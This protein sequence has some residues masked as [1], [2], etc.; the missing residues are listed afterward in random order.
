MSRSASPCLGEAHAIVEAPCEL[1]EGPSWDA[2][3]GEFRWLDILGRRLHRYRLEDGDHQS[4]ALDELVSF[5]APLTS[6]DDL[7]VTEH[8]L[9]ERDHAHGGVSPWREVEAANPVT[10][11]NDARI[12][13]HGGLWFSTMGKA[14]EAAAGSLYRLHRGEVF[15]LKQ[16]IT[17]PNALCFSPDGRLGYFTD[18]ATGVVMRWA[19]DAEGFPLRQDGGAFLQ[20]GVAARPEQLAEPEP[21]ADFNDDPGN[22]DGAV[23][24][25]DGYMWLALW[26]SGRVARLTPDGEEVGHVRVNADQPSC[27]AFGGRELTT[28]LITT[29]T[30]GQREHKEGRQDGATFL[31]DLSEALPGVRGLDDPPI[32]LR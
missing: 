10:R 28:L 30:E 6:G 19:L 26:G 4:Q 24:D 17:I 29:A 9:K 3:R 25:A 12:D 16:D 14:A 31:F 8:G 20:D 15:C 21:W 2:R 5:A 7:L 13:R 22:P 18:T 1:G 23:I 32:A 27:P 11:S